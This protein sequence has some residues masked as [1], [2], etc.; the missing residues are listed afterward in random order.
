M[1]NPLSFPPVFRL[2][3]L[4]PLVVWS[5][6]KLR[7]GFGPTSTSIWGCWLARQLT[8]LR[9]FHLLCLLSKIPLIVSKP[10]TPSNSG[11]MRSSFSWPFT[12]NTAHLTHKTS[13][14][15]CNL[16][17]PCPTM[18]P[19]EFSWLTTTISVSCGLISPC[20]G[21]CYTRNFS[22]LSV[23]LL[24]SRVVL[25][26]T[27]IARFPNVASPF[28]RAIALPFAVK[29]IAPTRTAALPTNAPHAMA[30]MLCPSAQAVIMSPNSND[31]PPPSIA[32]FHPSNAQLS[33]PL[34]LPTPVHVVRL[35]QLLLESRY[36]PALSRDICSGFTYGFPLS[37]QGD[38]SHRVIP[39]NHPSLLDNLS[40]TR[41]M[42]NQ[43]CNLGHIAGPFPLLPILN[44]VI[45]P[46]GLIP[47]AEH[48]KFC[49]IH[50]LSF[51]KGNSVNFGIPKEFCS[52]TYEDYDYF[53]S[54]LTSVGQ[55]CFIAKADIESAFRIIPVYP[56]DYHL[57]GFSF[58]RQ[59]YYD[60]CLPMGCSISC[61]I[62]EQFSCALQWILQT[63]CH[64]MHMS[65]IL[66]DYIFLSPSQSLCTSYLQQFFS[67]AE[68]L[69]IPI[70]HSK[71]VL[72]STCVVVHGIEIDTVK[73]EARLPQDKLDAANYPG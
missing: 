10:S 60:R 21:V 19:P 47:K 69:S 1:R 54:L 39:C 73:M 6:Q 26:P 7:N 16:S 17:A 27:S 57:L 59:Y 30:H 37:F 35:W 53:V 29:A 58:D 63:T 22:I 56:N 42:I 49:I 40:V 25:S 23:K 3:P 2:F 61:K 44:L 45:S 13:G 12:P 70:K 18:H 62:F 4:W 32:Q 71:T 14:S 41:D 52:V 48:R 66:D 67:L 38:L 68:W 72:P 28:Q 33:P 11:L 55:G 50:D 64:I 8:K 34:R 65:H 51:P 43:E 36:D 24:V 9:I 46:L 5:T 15:T 20:H 31:L